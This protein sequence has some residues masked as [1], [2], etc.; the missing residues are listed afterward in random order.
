MRLQY[1]EWK[2]DIAGY[3]V[4]DA[5]GAVV[6]AKAENVNPTPLG[7]APIA[8][9]Q[10]YSTGA[11][12]PAN[13]IGMFAARSSAG[14]YI[15][16]VGT[17]TKLYKYNSGTGTFDDYTRTSGG[18]YS[19]AAGEYWSATQFGSKVI[20]C[21]INDNP[22]VIDVD[23]AA[24]A[25]SD[26][27]GSPPK[28]RYVA[29]VGDFVIL[30]CLGSNNRMIQ[31][32]ALNDATGWTVGVNLSDTQEFPDGD[33]VTGISGGEYGWIVQEHAIRRLIFQPGYDT[34]FRCER[35][36]RERGGSSIYSVVGIR[37]SVF[38]LN[39]DGFYSFGPNGMTPIGHMRVNQWF[40]DN[41][42]PAR[43]FSVIAFADLTGPRICWA[44]YSSASASTFDRILI[45]DWLLDKWSYALVSA[46]FWAREVT[47]ATTLEG[48]NV[49]GA[50]DTGVP[51]S[52]DSPAWSGGVP[53]VGAITTAGKLAF[54][55]GS[56]LTATLVTCPLQLVQGMRAHVR[57]LFPLGVYNDATQSFRIGRRENTK[58][59]VNYT[60]SFS[61]STLSGIARTKASGRIHIV[62]H[63]ISQPSGVAWAHTQGVDI[64]VTPDGRK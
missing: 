47:A 14:G 58:D 53:V 27:G 12:L 4:R 3:D 52:L 15:I 13:C 33:R 54:L 41:S 40:R 11:A 20:F 59:S 39:Y 25:F 23:S 49:Y 30:A 64:T 48:L 1:G 34:A 37:D 22:Q 45:Y 62:E 38:M 9:L 7:F 6:L 63:T 19:V 29:V 36:E 56:P 35:V 51:Y 42:D 57:D 10:D 44:F 17:S 5:N 55:Q 46:Q 16:F 8:S 18:N 32:S 26:L 21:N 50:I 2:P 31:N 43:F 61:P 60:G 28:A 24:T